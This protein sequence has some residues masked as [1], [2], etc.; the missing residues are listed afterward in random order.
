MTPPIEEIVFQVEEAPEGGF[1]ARAL[2]VSITTQADDIEDLRKQVVD[3]VRC[4]FGE[5]PGL[6]RLIR[7]H[8][9]K[10]ELI[11]V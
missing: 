5:G 2:G 6:P 4:H 11:T 3:A 10:D 7:L 8:Q 9:V 1:I